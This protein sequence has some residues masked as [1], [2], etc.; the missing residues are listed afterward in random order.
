M[1]I[2]HESIAKQLILYPPKKPNIDPKT[3]ISVDGEESDEEPV[4]PQVLI[5][6]Q[7]LSLRYKTKDEDIGGFTGSS[8]SPNSYILTHILDPQ[9]QASLAIIDASALEH[10]SSSEE[11]YN[12]TSEAM[13]I[14]SDNFL[15][16]N[17]ELIKHQKE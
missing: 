14:N 3:P 10:K 15:K 6:D 17:I 8:S 4:S 12:P 2:S 1:T 9:F 13:D 5:V 11:E 16:I 7:Y